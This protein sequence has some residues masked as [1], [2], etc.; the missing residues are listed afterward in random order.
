MEVFKEGGSITLPPVLD[1]TNYVYRKARMI[2]FL[3]SLDT[4]TWKA[5]LTGWT[6]PTVNNIGVITVKPEDNWTGEE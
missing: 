3:K 1:R 2:A 4:S 6:T 5:I